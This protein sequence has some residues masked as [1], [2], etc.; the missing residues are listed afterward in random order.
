MM[1]YENVQNKEI[2]HG[3]HRERVLKKFMQYG[4][5]VFADYEL[6]E[7]LLMQA[8]PRKDVKPLAK[9]LLAQ[10]GSLSAIM[11]ADSEQLKSVK[12]VGDHTVA[13]LKMILYAGQRITKEKL[14]KAPVLADWNSM[15]DYAQLMYAGETVEKLRILFLNQKLQLMHSEIHQTGTVNHVPIYPREI[16][17]RALNLN[18]SAIILMHNH[19]SGD[20][21]PSKDDLMATKEIEKLLNTIPI[22]LLDHLIIGQN[23]QC[24]SFRAH[25]AL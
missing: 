15:L 23:H 16:L 5:D 8:I 12:G 4:G 18:A 7:L 2:G 13:F 1:P 24:Y 21:V 17:K 3:G 9:E 11:Q 19:P 6:L 20:P 10:F 14:N 22:R 25:H